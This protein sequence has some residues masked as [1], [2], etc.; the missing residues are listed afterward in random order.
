MKKFSMRIVGVATAAFMLAATAQVSSLTQDQT[1][2][3]EALLCLSSGQ[4]P[5][6]CTRSLQRYFSISFK[7]WSDTV[8]AR[9]DFL[10]MCPT[11][12]QSDNSQSQPGGQK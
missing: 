5:T 1:D 12:S 10:K 2:A 8:R 4:P 3:C 7:N 6:E 9:S 11:D